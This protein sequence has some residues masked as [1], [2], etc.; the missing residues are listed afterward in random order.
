MRSNRLAQVGEEPAPGFKLIGQ[1]EEAATAAAESPK[2]DRST[3]MILFALQALAKRT[4]IAISN[5]FTLLLAASAFV[6]WWS[7]LPNPSLQQ[8]S[9]LGMYAAFVLAFEFVR[10]R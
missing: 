7:V 9:G 10:R 8:L 2:E 1:E 5:M 4:L 6:L 3:R